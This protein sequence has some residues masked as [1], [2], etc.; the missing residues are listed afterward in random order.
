MQIMKAAVWR[1]SVGWFL[2]GNYG[3]I[4]GEIDGS[5]AVTPSH[6]GVL[7][8][9]IFAV[10]LMLEDGKFDGCVQAQ[11]TRKNCSKV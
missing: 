9:H 11:I 10:S 1:R 2:R 3:G 6:Y 8:L 4:E 7:C 5:W